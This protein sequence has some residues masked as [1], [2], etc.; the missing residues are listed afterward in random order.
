LVDVVILGAG[1]KAAA[2]EP[3]WLESLSSPAREV[4]LG[5]Y[6]AL[7]SLRRALQTI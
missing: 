1:A 2:V 6:R 3:E 5:A 4:A 7:S